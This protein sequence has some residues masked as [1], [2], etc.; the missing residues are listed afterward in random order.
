[1]R[2]NRVTWFSQLATGYVDVE[3]SQSDPTQKHVRP[4]HILG[5][6]SWGSLALSVSPVICDH[7]CWVRHVYTMKGEERRVLLAHTLRTICS[8]EQ[9]FASWC[10]TQCRQ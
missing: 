8:P 10:P 4:L 7:R 2:L 1:M 3:M 5:S 9:G 6:M